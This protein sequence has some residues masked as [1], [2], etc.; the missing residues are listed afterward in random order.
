MF[1]DRS[2]G[3]GGV[4][5]TN[6]QLDKAKPTNT[7]LHVSFKHDRVMFKTNQ[8]RTMI[9]PKQTQPTNRT[10]ENKNM[11]NGVFLCMRKIPV[12]HEKRVAPLCR[13]SRLRS[14]PGS[15]TTPLPQ[16]SP[17]RWSCIHRRNGRHNGMV[18]ENT[19]DM[20]GEQKDGQ[21]TCGHCFKPLENGC[22]HVNCGQGPP[23]VCRVEI[24]SRQ[25][26]G[27]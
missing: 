27:N 21:N 17:R 14:S 10:T 23:L 26:K 2:R 18:E 11:R 16:R 24:K 5:L 9:T 7:S 13:W 8:E 12:A 20:S 15:Q 6:T 3:G 25:P 22:C 4:C 1:Q 19:K